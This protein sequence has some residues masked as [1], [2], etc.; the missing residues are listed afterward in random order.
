MISDSRVVVLTILC[1]HCLVEDIGRPDRVHPYAWTEV[2]EPAKEVD[3]TRK[4]APQSQGYTVVG[5]GA[6]QS[7]GV[8]KE[9]MVMTALWRHARKWQI[10]TKRNDQKSGEQRIRDRIQHKRP[11]GLEY[12]AAFGRYVIGIGNMFQALASYDNVSALI[13]QRQR[14]DIGLDY[15]VKAMVAGDARANRGEVNADMEVALVLNV[16]MQ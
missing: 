6:S 14:V 16:G 8:D 12:S 4:E 9:P 1:A 10:L 7:V 15:V 5:A 13:G 3:D 11:A 2:E